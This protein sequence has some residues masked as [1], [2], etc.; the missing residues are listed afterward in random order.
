MLAA[1]LDQQLTGRADPTS[2]S[3]SP[4]GEE[5][6]VECLAFI[7]EIVAFVINRLGQCGAL[8]QERRFI[9]D[10]AAARHLGADRHHDNRSIWH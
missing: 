6:S 7:V 4:S 1:K 10:D 3:A 5:V 8:G 2:F 9:H